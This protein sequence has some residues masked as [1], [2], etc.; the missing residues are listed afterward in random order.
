MR[1]YSL[2]YRFFTGFM[3]FLTIPLFITG[4]LF[5]N[6]F[7]KYS[8]DEISK[9]SVGKLKI[10]HNI[11]EILMEELRKD[12]LSLSIN[13]SINA[14][15]DVKNYKL[16]HSDIDS[17]IKVSRAMDSLYEISRTNSKIHS[18]YLC[19][20]QAD[21]ILTTN[22]GIH[23][24]RDFKDQ[25]DF[26]L[27]SYINSSKY[28]EVCLNPRILT[29]GQRVISFIYPLNAYITNLNGKMIINIYED[30]FCKMVNSNNYQDEGEML[31]LDNSGSVVSSINK[32]LIG[33]NLL[34]EFGLKALIASGSEEGYILQ[35]K[36]Q[37]KQLITYYKSGPNGWIYVG[38]FSLA[39]LEINVASLRHKIIYILG[40]LILAGLVLSFVVS[41]RIYS[42]VSRLLQDIK[43]QNGITILKNENE[44]DVLSKAY[45]TLLKN[46][47]RIHELIEKNQKSNTDQYLISLL[48]GNYK[49]NESIRNLRIEYDMREYVCALI[50]V[51][52]YSDFN[53]AYSPEQ[54]YYMKSLMLNI[55]EEIIFP[56]YKCAGV[57]LERDRIALIINLTADGSVSYT[58]HLV[59]AFK[60]VKTELKNIISNTVTVGIGG[61]YCDKDGIRNSYVEAQNAVNRRML[62]GYGSIILNEACAPSN[63]GYLYP[64]NEEKHILNSV[65][66]G[67]KDEMDE[68][69]TEFFNNVRNEKNISIDNINQ[70][71]HQL[72]GAAVKYLVDSNI[73][74]IEVMEAETNIYEKIA[75]METLESIEEW[76]YNLF[77]R[78]INLSNTEEK[79]HI[80][81]IMDYINA[82]Y[83]RDIDINLL[84]EH[85]GLSYSYIRKVFKNETGKTIVDYINNL[86]IEEAKKLLS[87]TNENLAEIA[88]KL[89]YN[90]DQ[91]FTRF[92]K[93]YEG[94]TPGEFR[95]NSYEVN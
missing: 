36:G 23:L 33:K 13:N 55:A 69:V 22:M 24:K 84:A 91:S 21:Y 30:A 34:D 74:I 8:E 88:L 62:Q 25:N 7:L 6:L 48:N 41:R 45:H 40:S 95:R 42:P 78:I 76:F 27:M 10:I 67:L 94:V 35:H 12:V 54:Q 64:F 46:E 85:A 29:D 14:I 4:F 73:N 17:V 87:K 44:M 93:K 71:I 90:N 32:E 56:M 38:K 3:L 47:D 52:R 59:N 57:V 50:S 86:R 43:R 5:N 58:H 61:K 70:I 37:K 82:N 80:S 31:I 53:S 18:I 72:L 89:G 28:S 16:A 92:F 68:A 66:M 81:V 75:Q 19:T 51:D 79:G 9:S 39:K 15:I 60:Q 83:T 63:V 77:V 49:E 1:K 11:N 20:E 26:D 2:L 65:A